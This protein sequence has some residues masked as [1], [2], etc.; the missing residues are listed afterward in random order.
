MATTKATELGQLG[1]KLTV[2]NENI[3]LDGNVHGQYAGFDSDFTNAL[4]SNISVTGNI[5]VSGTVDGRDIAT[6]GT[7]LDGIETAATADQTAAEIKTLVGSA[8][9]SNV[10]TDADHT[11][12][13][14][15]ETAATA[16]QTKADIEGLGIDVPA[17]NLTGTIPAA[18]LSTATTQA[19][20]DDSTKIAT[21][22]YVV[23]KITTLI[24][25]APSTLNDLNELAAAINDDANYNSTLTTALATKLPLAGGTL[26]GNVTFGDNNKAIFGAGSDLQIYHDGDDSYVY[27][28]GAGNLNIQSNGTQI[29]LQKPDG[30]K[31]IEAINNGNVVVYSNGT[32]RLRA[33]GTGIDVTG[34]VTSDGLTVDGAAD[35]NNGAMFNGNGYN[36][37]LEFDNSGRTTFAFENTSTGTRMW[38]LTHTNGGLDLNWDPTGG[39]NFRI[40]GNIVVTQDQTSRINASITATQGQS[41]FSATYTVGAIDVFVNG[42]KLNASEYTATNGTSIVLDESC[43]ADDIFE[44]NSYGYVNIS[45]AVAS[46]GNQT[47]AG[48]LQVNDLTA[49]NLI[50]KKLTLTDDGSASPILAVKADD[51]GPWAAV[52]KNDT[53][54]TSSD[55]GLLLH[56]NDGGQVNITASGSGEYLTGALRVASSGGSVNEIAKWNNSYFTTNRPTHIDH[57]STTESNTSTRT[58]VNTDYGLCIDGILQIP[59][60]DLLM[61][62]DGGQKLMYSNDGDG[63]FGLKAGY[64]TDSIV[65][66]SSEYSAAGPSQINMDCDGT[67]PGMISLAAGPNAANGTTANLTAGIKIDDTGMYAQKPN[68]S[69]AGADTPDADNRIT[70]L[71]RVY[72]NF[73]CKAYASFDMT[74]SGSIYSEGNVSSVSIQSTGIARMNFAIAM[75]NS[76]YTVVGDANAHGDGGNSGGL[77]A[78]TYVSGP[79]AN[80]PGTTAWVQYDYRDQG[81]TNINKRYASMIVYGEG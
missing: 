2:H 75:P 58:A 46:T 34:T 53:Y 42:V 21:T 32:E 64:G 38:S 41:T 44:V 7:K 36:I 13:D 69:Y 77:D 52:I 56:Q 19:E 79:P 76:D 31:M 40:G 67:N 65:R 4:S 11:K 62:F 33:N 43:N 39:G 3:T 16:D 47:I 80:Q 68:S 51:N 22:A 18:R 81:S 6:D 10:F 27:D 49:D 1:S 59:H 45:G 54:S 71:D 14:G 9:D 35:F 78:G 8:T 50:A 17:T 12:L 30:T 73:I 15:I 5:S 57:N 37:D 60:D 70:N 26:T 25:G 24:G 61:E 48:N 74:S 29:N 20:S 63:N 72:G 66:S 28:A 23:D 55:V